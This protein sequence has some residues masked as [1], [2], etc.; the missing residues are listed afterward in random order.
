M[1]IIKKLTNTGEGV[2]KREPSYTLGGDVNWYNTMENTMELKLKIELPCDLALPLLGVNLE[3][4]IIRKDTC[5]Q[6][7]L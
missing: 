1:A 3:K 6:C 4:T 7:A 5:T 2:E